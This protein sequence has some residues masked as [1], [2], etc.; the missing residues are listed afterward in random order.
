MTA[1]ANAEVDTIPDA[2]ETFPCAVR[3]AWSSERVA[4]FLDEAV[5]PM[6]L[7]VQGPDGFP[8]ILSIWFIREGGTL[9]GAVH[10]DS[11]VVSRLRADDR[12]A[13]EIAPNHPPYRGVRGRARVEIVPRRGRGVLTRLL[14]RYL[15]GIDSTL[16]RWLLSRA[17]DEFALVL[18]PVTIGTW[19]YTERMDDTRAG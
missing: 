6:R 19:D 1:L 13:F 10:K 14:E 3:G 15:G 4:R 17:D 16:A 8:A 18:H 5:L 9:L 11:R 7:A 2:D 12:C